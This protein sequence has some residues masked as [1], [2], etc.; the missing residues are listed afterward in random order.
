[1]IKQ[2][3]IEV[4]NLISELNDE[5]YFGA[6]ILPAVMISPYKMETNGDVILISCMGEPVWNSDNDPGQVI[7]SVKQEI[8][9]ESKDVWYSIK[10]IN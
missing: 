1:M 4:F 8:L 6:E 10:L 3:F 7:E 5:A 9:N 2:L